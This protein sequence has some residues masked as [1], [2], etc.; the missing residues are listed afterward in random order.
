MASVAKQA[1]LVRGMA[2][3]KPRFTSWAWVYFG[4]YICLPV[5]GVAFVLDLILY[6]A[7][8]Y[9]MDSCYGVLCLLQ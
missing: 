7:F 1:A 6:L 4:L 3:P 5:L 8:R 9:L 2:F